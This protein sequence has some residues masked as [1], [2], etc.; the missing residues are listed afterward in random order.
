M[1]DVFPADFSS[2]VG[3]VRKYIPDLRQVDGEYIFSD[4][5]LESFVSDHT[6]DLTNPPATAIMR[7]AGFAM[8]ALAN[9]ENLILKKIKTEDQET[10]GPAV[11]A[12]LIAAAQE[13]FKRAELLEF[14]N[15]DAE[16]FI[17]VDY[18]PTPPRRQPLQNV[19]LRRF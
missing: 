1:V 11:A 12:R 4:A 15:G 14:T 9:D 16:T 7:A 13:M 19:W 5:E 18:A 10:D 17:S 2:A 3:R 8:L 6:L